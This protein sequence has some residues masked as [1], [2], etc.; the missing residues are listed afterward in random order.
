[1]Y[2]DAGTFCRGPTC[3]FEG[4][5]APIVEGP[6]TV[7]VVVKPQVVGAAAGAR[8]QLKV[9]NVV[10]SFSHCED[11]VSSRTKIFEEVWSGDLTL[12]AESLPG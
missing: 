8:F 4:H 1:M 5:V 3:T 6:N 7:A 12:G 11:N 2:S 10:N 9:E